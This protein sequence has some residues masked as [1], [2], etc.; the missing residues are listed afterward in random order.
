MVQIDERAGFEIVGAHLHDGLGDLLPI[1]PDVLDGS[2]SY[3][4]GN[5]GKTLDPG[6]AVIHRVKDDV[7]PILSRANF[8]ENALPVP[9][10]ALRDGHTDAQDHSIKSRVAYQ[11]VAS[12]AKN[13]KREVSFLREAHCLRYLGF[14]FHFTEETRRATDP[15][16]RVRGKRNKLLKLQRGTRHGL[17]VQ[18]RLKSLKWDSRQKTNAKATKLNAKTAT[19]SSSSNRAL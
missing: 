3:V 1:G 12:S 7:V 5:A 8:K 11:Q 9:A 17:R 15:K 16:R 18:H 14:V 13:K 2:T 10:F 4:S 6:I 19:L